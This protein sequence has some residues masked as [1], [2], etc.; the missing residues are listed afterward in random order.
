MR[1]N[2]TLRGPVDPGTAVGDWTVLGEAEPKHGIRHLLCR[3]V[4]G[5]ERDVGIGGLRTGTSTSCGC[6]NFARHRKH[7]LIACPEYTIWRQLKQRCSNPKD[8]AFKN[9][10]GRGIHVC[11]KWRTSFTAFLADVGPRPDPKLTLD[12]INNDGN[13]EPGNVRWATRS[14]Q[15]LNTRLSREDRV[16]LGQINAAKRWH[17]ESQSVS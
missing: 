13:Y 4:C 12:R 14:Q 2:G 1:S 11:A 6:Q 5:A 16:R 9:Y 8:R 15:M 10:G 3:C 17:P 7:G